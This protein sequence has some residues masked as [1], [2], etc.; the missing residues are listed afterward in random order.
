MVDHGI[1][2]VYQP[3]FHGFGWK[4]RQF[5]VRVQNHRIARYCK[6]LVAR[7]GSMPAF[8]LVSGDAHGL[9]R[10]VKPAEK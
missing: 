6:Y 7:Y 2:P 10:G 9:D 8:W 4:G 5:S 1:V 3:V